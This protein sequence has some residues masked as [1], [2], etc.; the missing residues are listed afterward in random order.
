MTNTYQDR[1]SRVTD[2]IYNHLHETLDLD[3]LADMAALSRWHWHRVYFAMRGETVAA[4]VRRL[5]LQRASADLVLT[6][7]AIA[8]ISERAGYGS[9]AAF[10][11]AFADAY[12]MPPANY[13]VHGSHAGLDPDREDVPVA[14]FDV[15]IVRMAPLAVVVEE[16]TGSY[17]QIDQA[18]ERLFGRLGAA[19]RLTAETGMVGVYLSDPTSVE[20]VDLKSL[21]GATAAAQPG[22]PSCLLAGGD[23]AVLRHKGPYADMRNA[24]AW[25]FGRWLPQS[26]RELAE[27]PVLEFYLN[28]PRE[29][30]PT[31][32]LTDLYL[33]LVTP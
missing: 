11:R 33:P 30:P 2:Y 29:V 18:F 27:E 17:M 31:E 14:Q 24:Y 22:E 25:M 19:G 21:A 4:A 3:T 15:R 20:E 32:L 28:N 9:V 1:I 12:G 16:H 5:R 23:Y 8:E 26:G 7:R 10:T 13:R 6:E